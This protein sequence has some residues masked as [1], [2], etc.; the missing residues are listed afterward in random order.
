MK[1]L[2][3]RWKAWREARATIRQIQRM[4]TLLRRRDALRMIR[5]L[6]LVRMTDE[7]R[8]NNAKPGN[9]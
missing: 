7:K 5:R 8:D 3:S 2:I 9:E 1:K 4:E 6:E